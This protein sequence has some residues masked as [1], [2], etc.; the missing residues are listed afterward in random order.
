MN[1]IVSPVPS[2]IQYSDPGPEPL[3]AWKLLDELVVDHR[4]QRTTDSH[5]SGQ[6]IRL[7]AQSF[8]WKKCQPLIVCPI[9]G[10]KFAIIDGQHRWSAAKIHP[11]VT[12][13]PCMV[14]MAPEIKSQAQS[15]MAINRDRVS[16]NYM[17]MHHA[18][19]AAGEPD[20]VHVQQICDQA[21]VKLPKGPKSTK[22]LRLGQS[23][24]IGAISV[25]LKSFGDG[26]VLR[27]LKLL[28]DAYPTVCGALRGTIVSGMIQFFAAH[29]GRAIDHA[30]LTRVVGDMVPED[31]ERN[32]AAYRKMFKGTSAGAVRIAITKAYNKG[33]GTDNRL[34]E[35]V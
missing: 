24:A 26:P 12:R 20:A 31:L 5:R 27:A 4:Y 15:F 11:T 19:V 21:G 1:H 35:E 22:D 30:R 10:G 28:I 2:S 23:L 3:L 25:G 9:D 32:A 16:V 18:A 8:D 29:K 34:P 17:A 14:V 13:L 33:L 6:V 7:I